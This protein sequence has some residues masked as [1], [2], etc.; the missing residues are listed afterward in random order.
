MAIHFGVRISEKKGGLKLTRDN[1][2]TVNKKNSIG[3]SYME[4]TDDWCREHLD[5]CMKNYD[6]NSEYFSLLNKAEFRAEIDEFIQ[7]NKCFTEIFDLNLCAG[8][9]GYYIMVLDEYCQL[10][11][12]TSKNI[13]TR[14]MSHWSKTMYFDRLIY[15]TVDSSIL[16]IDSFRALDTTRIFANLTEETFNLEDRFINQLS[17]KY[18]CN[19]TAGGELTGG[20][21][22]ANLMRKTR[23]L[24]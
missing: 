15:G 16:S 17:H 11:I 12:G 3:T 24:K 8:K 9:P 21:K 2:A 6:L 5:N 20:L 23:K 18:V 7:N 22:E 13:K 4:Y 1:Y 14:I 10:Y 19:R